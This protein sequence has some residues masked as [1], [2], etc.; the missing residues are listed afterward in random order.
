MHARTGNHCRTRHVTDLTIELNLSASNSWVEWILADQPSA[1][2]ALR[3]ALRQSGYWFYSISKREIN[4]GSSS[5][6][7]AHKMLKILISVL[8]ERANKKKKQQ[9]QNVMRI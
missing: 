8:S 3:D 6:R 7:H 5:L 2:I 9:L 1:W 4:V